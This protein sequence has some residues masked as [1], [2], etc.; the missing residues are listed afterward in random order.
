MGGAPATHSLVG[1]LNPDRGVIAALLPAA[2]RDV[3]LRVNEANAKLRTQQQM[4]DA[5]SC[6]PGKGVAEI[7]PKRVDSLVRMKRA[8]GVGPTLVKKAEICGAS[9]WGEQR[10]VEPALGLVHIEIVDYLRNQR[11]ATAVTP[12]SA[13]ARAG[14]PVAAPISW[15]EM[16]TIE[17]PA[18][19]HVGDASEL[20][21]RATSKSLMGWGR[22]EQVLS[23]L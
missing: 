16:E 15:S 7:I 13:R 11:G 14:A 3:D 10:I 20:V 4:I 22:T 1:K 17:S 23:G 6:V 2:D 21:R 8:K 5:Q 12:Y 9:F 19:F 18:R